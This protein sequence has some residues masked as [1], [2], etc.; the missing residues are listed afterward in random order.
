MIMKKSSWLFMFTLFIST[1]MT[2]SSN[3]W[4]SMWMGLEL[5]MM[6][7]I[8]LILNKS[9]K[10]SSEAAMI[11]FLIQSM[12]SMI[13]LMMIMMIMN[14]YLI[15]FNLM[16][17]MINF[18]LL[19]KLGAAPFHMWLPEIMS[20]MEWSKCMILMTWQKIAPL[21]I[22]SNMS[23]SWIINISI[24]WSVSI[25]CLGG[26]NQSS[27][28]KI[29]GYSSINHLGWL[30]AIN[31]TMNLWIIYLM[32]YSFMILLM[33]KMFINYKLYFINQMNMV[34][35]N[36]M[37]K[38]NMFMM[39]LS[40]GGLPPL[41]GFLPKWITIQS[42]MNNKEFIMLLFMVMCSLI[43]LMYYLRI[44]TS[45][46][47]SYNLSNKWM[48]NYHKNK[49]FMFFIMLVNLSLPLIMIL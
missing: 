18:S 23:Y 6:S 46:Y 26:I 43:T 4:I 45:M 40:M 27:L 25:G 35:M 42:M 41:I 13:L 20:K 29:M 49:P 5:N 3:N 30:L 38:F 28:R 48:I 7:F 34:N 8:P 15:D 22:I 1:I 47:L 31:K 33:C 17:I 39:M 14:K 9:N 37:E 21:F 32:I 24:I 44:M 16:I 10:S 11:Y 12:S 2:L 19:M 36:N